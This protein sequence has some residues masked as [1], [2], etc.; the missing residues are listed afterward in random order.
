VRSTWAKICSVNALNLNFEPVTR[1]SDAFDRAAAGGFFGCSASMLRPQELA[2]PRRNDVRSH[3]GN[4]EISGRVMLRLSSSPFDPTETLAA[5]FA[6]MHN[7]V[8]PT[9][10]V[11]G[12][13]RGNHT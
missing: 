10:G 12:C 7:A 2:D 1:V 6:V 5:K 4:W 11:V 13:S 3:V 8:F 9:H